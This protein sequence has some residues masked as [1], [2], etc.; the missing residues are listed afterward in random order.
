M[1]Q[2]QFQLLAS[3]VLDETAYTN[4]YDES[5]YNDSNWIPVTATA[6]DFLS[7]NSNRDDASVLS[8]KRKVKKAIE[9]I[10]KMDPGYNAVVDQ[11]GDKV[12][13]FY[14]TTPMPGGK[15]RDAVTGIRSEEDKVGTSRESLYFKVSYCGNNGHG[16]ILFFDSP[17][18]YERHFKD[19]IS[20]EIKTEWLDNKMYIMR[21][22]GI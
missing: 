4:V 20:P 12:F 3:S 13:E 15:I 21:K 7:V 17:E 14:E 22:L 16:Q 2:S 18:S 8:K 9:D 10:K 11:S 6:E 5:Y 19:T 1:A